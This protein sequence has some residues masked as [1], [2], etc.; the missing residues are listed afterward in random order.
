MTAYQSLSGNLVE[1]NVV[2]SEV[3]D[4]GSNLGN[5]GLAQF[6]MIDQMI[7]QFRQREEAID[8]T[9]SYIDNAVQIGVMRYF[10]DGASLVYGSDYRPFIPTDVNSAKACLRVEFWNRLLNE[11][12]IFDVM[13]TAKREQARA[14]FAGLECP[15][16]DETTVRPT[17]ENL[18]QQR[19]N[20]FSERV[21]GIFR[22]LSG[23]HVTNSPS[24]FSKKM[25]LSNVHSDGYV[26]SYKGGII[27][28]LRGVVGRLS[29]R[30][31]PSEYGTRKLLGQVYR[32][33]LGKK[34]AIDGGAFHIT[35][36][37]NGN[38]HFEVA[39]EVAIELNA[40]LANL[41]PLAIPAKFRTVSKKPKTGSF[42]LRTTRLPMGVIDL[43][44]ALENRRDFYSLY[45]YSK[46]EQFVEQA[47]T[48]LE[49]I[50]ADVTRSADKSNL[51]VKFDY[52][53]RPV[54]DQLVFGGV[55]PEQA[56]YQFYPTRSSI[57]EFAASKLDIQLGLDYCEPSAGTGDLAQFLPKDFTTC[58]EL[59]D[60]RAKVLQAKGYKTFKADFLTWAAENPNLRFDGMLMNPPFSKGRALAHIVAA[61]SLL[62]S[63]GRI[64]AI[65]PSSMINSSPLPGFEHEWSEVFVD[66]FEG[67]AVRVSVLTAT[68]SDRGAQ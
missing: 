43:I 68:R 38:A 12:Q 58:I 2:A 52:D 34:V 46:A 17:I 25:I 59:A 36:F 6:D 35:L 62:K 53:A 27:S 3:I 50:G 20:F 5:G 18:L 37:K 61:S 54:I 24:G 11:A 9:K 4:T 57:G 39:P 47:I 56:S 8:S 26:E 19:S 67:T 55:V 64:V 65:L 40:I 16:F 1:A 15:P 14:Q 7:G 48:V 60:V 31:E 45:V 41:Y 63:N 32:N 51:Y 21:D 22:G 23:E 33:H 42:E 49:D 28:D 44:A 30:G 66:Q 10:M 29:G 13:P